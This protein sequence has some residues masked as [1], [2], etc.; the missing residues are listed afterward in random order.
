[1]S[2]SISVY[3]HADLLVHALLF[4]LYLL[5]ELLDGSPVRR[6]TVCLEN[7]DIPSRC[8]L[9]VVVALFWGDRLICERRDLLLFYFVVGKVLL[10][11]L[12]A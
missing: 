1:V 10:V 7:L 2:P 5:L 11:L 4:L 3:L 6:G 12:P 8:Q 9:R